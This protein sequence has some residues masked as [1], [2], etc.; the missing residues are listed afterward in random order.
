MSAQGTYIIIKY[1]I[2]LVNGE[3]LGRERVSIVFIR[4][5]FF[6]WEDQQKYKLPDLQRTDLLQRQRHMVLFLQYQERS[7][8]TLSW[9]QHYRRSIKTIIIIIIIIIIIVIIIIII[10]T[11]LRKSHKI[12]QVFH[13]LKNY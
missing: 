6:V 11:L 4:K 13:Q 8:T 3:P 5:F 9:V 2:L 12:T 7:A 10:I 1:N